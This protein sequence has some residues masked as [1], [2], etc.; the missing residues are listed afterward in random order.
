MRPASDG[1]GISHC[2]R[3]AGPQAAVYIAQC[4][5]A[6]RQDLTTSS[7]SALVAATEGSTRPVTVGITNAGIASVEMFDLRM[8]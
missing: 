2:A 7:S 6:I 1:Q 8:P 4:P 3:G 5:H